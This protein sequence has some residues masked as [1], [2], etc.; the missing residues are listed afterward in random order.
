MEIK[1]KIEEWLNG[2]KM[3]HYLLSKEKR[4][5]CITNK[6]HWWKESTLLESKAIM[7][8]IVDNYKSPFVGEREDNGL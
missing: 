1:S 6:A 5:Y 2:E 3:S 8:H 7:I 4:C